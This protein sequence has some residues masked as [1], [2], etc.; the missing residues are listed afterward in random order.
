MGPASAGFIPVSVVDNL[1][2]SADELSV[3]LPNGCQLKGI[4]QQTV[5]VAQILLKACLL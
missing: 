5:A 2:V 3:T 4:N 1:P